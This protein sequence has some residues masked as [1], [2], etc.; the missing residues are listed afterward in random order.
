MVD[1][2][3]FGTALLQTLRIGMLDSDDNKELTNLDQ[4]ACTQFV[5]HY[6]EMSEAAPF[7][8]RLRSTNIHQLLSESPMLLLSIIVTASSSNANVQQQAD[9]AFLQVIADRVIVQGEKRMEIFQSLL[10]YL[11]WYHLRFDSQKQQFYQFIQLANGMAADLS[12]PRL[13]AQPTETSVL[14]AQVI[15]QARALLHCYYLNIG[16]SALGFDRAETM[17]CPQSLRGA[18]EVLAKA[19]EW[20][21]DEDAPATLELM[22]I[23]SRHQKG[24]REPKDD[25]QCLVELQSLHDSLCGWRRKVISSSTQSMLAPTYHFITA[26]TFLKSKSLRAPR[27]R[28][29]GIGLEACQAVLSHI[30]EKP[31]SHLVKL[32]IVE[33][34]HLI[35][36]L[37]ILPW[38]EISATLDRST[39][40]VSLHATSTRK[41]ISAFRS[42][43]L[44]LRLRSEKKT[45]FRAEILFGWLETILTAVET[46]AST[47]SDRF[48]NQ[49]NEE[50]TAYELVNSFLRKEMGDQSQ[51]IELSDGPGFYRSKEDSWLDFMSD[52]LDW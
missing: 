30:L 39:G 34:A 24:M 21:L 19:R 22:V 50:E 45:I 35:T 23:A 26:Y 5:D 46:R 48:S 51:S 12:L 7:A 3:V 44:D 6:Q 33:W 52:W 32:S 17:Q 28:A 27:S 2:Q 29:L 16:G 14:T 9:R 37:F 38:L 11:N 1:P 43:L 47:L 25:A 15:D 36:T 40:S 41:L 42:Q 4:K 10:I 13:F 8:F 20:P 31:S 18:A 49:A